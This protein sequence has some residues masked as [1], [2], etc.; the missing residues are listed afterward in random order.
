MKP[1]KENWI[2]F[3]NSRLFHKN[4]GGFMFVLALT[5]LIYFVSTGFGI[6]DTFTAN[7]TYYFIPIQLCNSIIIGIAI[8]KIGTLFK[9]H[10]LGNYFLLNLLKISQILNIALGAVSLISTF[11]EINQ[12]TTT[13]LYVIIFILMV[14]SFIDLSASCELSDKVNKKY[15]KTPYK[16][17]KMNFK[18]VFKRAYHYWVKYFWKLVVMFV[19]LN[20]ISKFIMVLVLAP[21]RGYLLLEEDWLLTWVFSN[22]FVGGDVP[23]DVLNRAQSLQ[24]MQQAQQ[25]MGDAVQVTF[26]F[27]GIGLGSYMIVKGYR[28]SDQT[29]FIQ[30]FKRNKPQILRLI[31][32]AFIVAILYTVGLAILFIPGIIVYV[33]CVMVMPNVTVERKYHFIQNFGKSKDLISKNF[34]RMALYT[35]LI[36]FMKVGL[37]FPI[38][39]INDAIRGGVGNTALQELLKDP[40]SN[41]GSIFLLESLYSLL[42]AFVFPLEVA[43]ISI[44]FIDLSYRKTHKFSDDDDDGKTLKGRR[45]SKKNLDFDKRVKRANYCPTCGLSVRKGTRRCPNCQSAIN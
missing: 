20:L 3:A 17:E 39:Y 10:I 38:N 26:I 33:Y 21:W 9:T 37:Q 5:M 22:N 18:M 12:D 31:P 45:E 13:L 43:F 19:I 8:I 34:G 30:A 7:Q 35:I 1:S 14:V 27:I 40:I 24:F 4:A 41:F 6:Y 32:L 2:N 44:L 29:S 23:A 11:M 42:L 36:F 16:E 15:L 28:G 25:I